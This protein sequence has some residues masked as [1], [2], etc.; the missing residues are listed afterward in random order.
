MVAYLK[1]GPQVR[2]Y[3][4]YLRAARE[5]KKED[6]IELS[7]SPRAPAAD[8]YTKVRATSFFS[9]EEIE[10]QPAIPK[11]THCMPGTIGGRECQ[12]Q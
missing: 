6:S 5:A 9:L 10:G 4:D 8:D 2:T 12:R 1:A 3:S 7:R 11:E